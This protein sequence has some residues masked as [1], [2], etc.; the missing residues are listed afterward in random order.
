MVGV[1]IDNAKL[2]FTT[3]I[4]PYFIITYKIPYIYTRTREISDLTATL[5]I[6]KCECFLLFYRQVNKP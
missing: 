5:G 2:T 3:K 4:I 6:M 1:L